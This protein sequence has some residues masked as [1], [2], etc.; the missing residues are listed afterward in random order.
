LGTVFELRK[1]GT[2]GAPEEIADFDGIK[3][4]YKVI[5]D[6]FLKGASHHFST[7]IHFNFQSFEK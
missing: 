1:N 5:Y 3:F 2:L 6:A 7:C 4:I